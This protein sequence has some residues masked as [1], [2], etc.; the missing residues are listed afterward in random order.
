MEDGH[1]K[2][3]EINDYG[4]ELSPGMLVNA[5][6]FTENGKKP[7]SLCLVIAGRYVRGNEEHVSCYVWTIL[8]SSNQRMFYWKTIQG[9]PK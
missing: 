5:R 3:P 7:L 1:V 9:W 8:Q 2:I 6:V 4:I